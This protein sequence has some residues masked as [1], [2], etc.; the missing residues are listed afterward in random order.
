M[1]EKPTFDSFSIYFGSII[2]YFPLP[3]HNVRI[4]FSTLVNSFLL[5]FNHMIKSDFSYTLVLSFS[6]F[7]T[8]LNRGIKFSTLVLFLLY[9]HWIMWSSYSL[10]STTFPKTR[11]KNLYVLGSSLLYFCSFWRFFL[12]SY[13]LWSN[14][15]LLLFNYV[16]LKKN[17]IYFGPVI[18]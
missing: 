9:N 7:P 2:L 11:M 3:S 16:I 1:V 17:I 18:I 5:L 13:L 14:Y 12:I 10:L 4:K 8:F 15:S 6:T